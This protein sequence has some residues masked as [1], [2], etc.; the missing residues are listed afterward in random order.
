MC[1]HLISITVDINSVYQE[2]H[3]VCITFPT[4]ELGSCARRMKFISTNF[5]RNLFFLI[6]NI[7][8]TLVHQN[9]IMHIHIISNY[10]D[11]L[12]DSP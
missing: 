8:L 7:V 5:A 2:G 10:I 11:R 1:Y 4:A 6:P 9:T 12:F 3:S